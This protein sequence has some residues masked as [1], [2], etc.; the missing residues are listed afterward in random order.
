ML[1]RKAGLPVLTI[2]LLLLTSTP[3]VELSLTRH[4]VSRIAENQL[5]TERIS[6]HIQFLASDKL[7]GRR[8]GTPFA[9]QAAKY[10]ES[11]F[12]SYGLK[13]AS[14][15]GFLQ[16]FTFVSSV[17]LG[18]QNSF[19]F[20]SPTGSQNL[21]V[22][23][24]FMPLAF[25]PSQPV[26]GEAVF[27]GYGISAPEL[28]LDSYAGIDAKGKIAIVLRGSPDGDNPHG[29]F[30]EFTQPGLEIQNKTLKAREKGATGVLFVSA[31]KSF[32]E[33]RLS[34]LH[35]DLNFLDSGIPTA[36]LSRDAI[37][38]ILTAAGASLSDAEAKAKEA[39]SAFKL[40]DVTIKF[41]TDVV[42]INGT[43]TNV[44]GVLSGSDPQLASEYVV[45]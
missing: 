32:H 20:K 8:A 18:D 42:K 36:V 28:G 34:R 39:N 4:A 17:K 19:E 14:P 22:T 15:A 37:A 23:E 26:S 33:D 6:K 43:S 30:A 35:H 25:S 9:D 2:S 1:I 5:S 12:R 27:V 45:L 38:S 21:K 44:V 10:I 11:E 40:K 16:P 24:A 7:Q 13:P 41:K 29:K 3:A 31:E